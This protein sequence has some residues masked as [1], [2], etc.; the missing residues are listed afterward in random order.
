[1]KPIETKK[2]TLCPLIKVKKLVLYHFLLPVDG[3][4]GMCE[5]NPCQNGGM[6]RRRSGGQG[7][8]QCSAGFTGVHCEQGED[9]TYN[10]FYRNF[11]EIVDTFNIRHH[12]I[13]MPSLHCDAFTLT[14]SLHSVIITSLWRH[15]L[16]ILIID[17]KRS[18][19]M[20]TI[21]IFP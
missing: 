1:M 4:G 18:Q 11:N 2:V 3:G 15:N 8:C 13:Q 12:V 21:R 20:C 16:S 7:Y 17:S 5:S 6:C 10:A 9:I 19:N 14:S